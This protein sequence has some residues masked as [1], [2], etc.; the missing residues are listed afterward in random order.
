M[1][2]QL[3]PQDYKKLRELQNNVKLSRR[4]YRKVTVLVMLH[5]GHSI[6]VVE[7]ALGLDDN[8]IRRY[9]E[10]YEEQGIETYLADHYV[11]YSGK[12]TSEQEVTLAHHLE[13]HLYLD[14]KPIIAWV[15]ESFNIS[16]SI[17][18]MR[19]L[20]RRL[21]FVYKQT[22]AVPSKADEEAQRAFLEDQLPVLL[23]EVGAGTAE[24]Y[25]GNGV[26]PTHNTKTGRGWI[27]KGQDFEVDCN[28]GR[29]R[30]NIN[31]AVRATKP[32]HMVYDVTDTIN[33][34]STQR[35][36]R[37]LLRKHPGKT[38]YYICDNAAYNR[39]RWLQEW[40]KAQR[41][42]F[43][44]LPA[45]SPN[46]NLIERLWRLLRKEAINSVYYEAYDDFRRGVIDF[47]DNA[48][49][50]KEEIRSL[51]TLNFR[52]VDGTSVYAQ[53]TS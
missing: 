22:K 30:V 42:E 40:A 14:V 8:T 50:Y 51:L 13:E 3:S 28:S 5:Q 49:L 47:L 41:I 44:F 1:D 31:G 16:Y 43:I 25:H 35:V 52:T 19:D 6:E 26:H 7:A 53:T 46:L 27:R 2:Y 36:C 21:G 48:K 4:R 9:W 15:E 10:G 20:L 38:I 32:E 33:A 24:V 23:D 29:K 39:C 11:P 18:G 34:Q 12:L 17:S 45:Y 37:Q